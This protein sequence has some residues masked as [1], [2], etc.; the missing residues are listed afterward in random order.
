MGV[1]SSHLIQE[2][3]IIHFNLKRYKYVI[4]I[5]CHQYLVQIIS[6]SK[7]WHWVLEKCLGELFALG[8]TDT[9]VK[10]KALISWATVSSLNGVEF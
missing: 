6:S 9:W 8:N 5:I 3:L 10:I 7:C 1:S 4:W 2:S